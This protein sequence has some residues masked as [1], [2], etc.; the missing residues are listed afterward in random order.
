MG[1]DAFIHKYFAEF[2]GGS[3]DNMLPDT[4]PKAEESEK[5]DFSDM[6]SAKYFNPAD[7]SEGKN[8][9]GYDA[10]KDFDMPF[11]VLIDTVASDDNVITGIASQHGVTREEAVRLYR[12]KVVDTLE[13]CGVYVSGWFD[14]YTFDT[15]R[16]YEYRI[17]EGSLSD[18]P[19]FE[20]YKYED[21]VYKTCTDLYFV[22]FATGEALD[23]LKTVAEGDSGLFKVKVSP[24][25]CGLSAPGEAAHPYDGTELD[26]SIISGAD[27]FYQII[28]CNITYK[29]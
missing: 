27:R 3:P 13:K 15:L 19:R 9:V 12:G 4:A 25:N 22:A 10:V 16:G 29:Y 23:A 20:D 11:G 14:L 26:E 1:E 21:E 8:S 2:E 7:N 24:F 17:S 28:K 6:Y 18:P 5:A